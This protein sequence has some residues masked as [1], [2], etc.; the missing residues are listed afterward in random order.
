MA[1]PPAISTNDVLTYSFVI[2]NNGNVTLQNV[3]VVDP[4]SGLSALFCLPTQGSSLAPNAIMNCTATYTVTQADFD[5]GEITNLATATGTAPDGSNVLDTSS[6]LVQTAPALP[7]IALVNP[8]FRF[9][10]QLQ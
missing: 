1:T 4:L 6:N 10:A 7:A 8:P 5:R 3:T 2:V 9:R